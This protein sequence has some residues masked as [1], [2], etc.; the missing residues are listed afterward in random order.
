[1]SIIQT[2]VQ[3]ETQKNS[4]KQVRRILYYQMK[5]IPDVLE[6]VEGETDELLSDVLLRGGIVESKTEFRRLVEDG[7]VSNLDT[8]EKIEDFFQKIEGD[9][10]LKIGKKRFVEIRKK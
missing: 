10:K 3:V 9:M 7:A 2:K 8:K 4:K 6:Q 1:M 5:E